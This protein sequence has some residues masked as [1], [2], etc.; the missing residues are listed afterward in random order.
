MKR[1]LLCANFALLCCIGIQAQTTLPASFG[2]D[3][4]GATVSLE[5][6]T[7]TINGHGDLTKMDASFLF[8]NTHD[9]VFAD[10][11]GTQVA[12]GTVFSDAS[13]YYTR[14]DVYTPITENFTETYTTS[15]TDTWREFNATAANQVYKIG[16]DWSSH[17][18]TY[19]LVK[20][21]DKVN[22]TQIWINGSNVDPYYKK[23]EDGTYTAISADEINSDTYTTE[24]SKTYSVYSNCSNVF[25]KKGNTYS[26]VYNGQNVVE[27]RDYF[28]R[29]FDY[30]P[31]S[32]DDL[33]D[34]G[35][36]YSKSKFIDALVEH[37]E[38]ENIVFV[39]DTPSTPLYIN[40]DILDALFYYKKDNQQTWM[41]N[42]VLKELDLGQTT[43]KNLSSKTFQD[44]PGKPNFSLTSL[45]LPLS[46]SKKVPA[47]LFSPN[48][49]A[50]K[51]LSKIVIPE[52]YTAIGD[53]AF[54]NMRIK[55]VVFPST[56][57][58][59]GNY[60]FNGCVSIDTLKLN[61]GL[62][63]IGKYAF[64]TDLKSKTL[65][66][67]L[68]PSTL[69]KIDD[70][71]F[72]NA[73]GLRDITFNE[74]LRYIGNS[75]FGC[76]SNENLGDLTTFTIPSSVRF[77]GS[78]AFFLRQYQDVFFESEVAP[79]MPTG[80]SV[81]NTIQASAKE[82][83]AFPPEC[84]Q[85]NSGFNGTKQEGNTSDDVKGTGYANRE[86]YK[87]STGVY[88]TMLHY[89]NNITD[90]EKLSTYTDTLR[91]Y[92]TW[93]PGQAIDQ[94]YG[95]DNP[96]GKLTVG[97]ETK[98][99]Y[100]WGG[101][102]IYT[103]VDYGFH[104]TYVGDRY[105]WPSQAQWN[106]AYGTALNG[107]GYDGVTPYR[108]KL[109]DEELQILAEAGYVV[110]TGEGQYSLD[111]L[112]EIAHK[113]TRMFVFSNPDT[114][115]HKEYDIKM[116]GGK[117]WTLCVP[118]NMTKKQVDEVFGDE[119]QVCLFNK[120]RRDRNTTTNINSI[121]LFFTLDVCHHKSTKKSENG[122]WEYETIAN[123]PAPEDDDIVIYAHE[124]YMIHPSK[125]P[126]DAVFVVKDYS[127][128]VGNPSPTIIA[129]SE[130]NGDIQ[131]S[132]EEGNEYRFVGNYIGG[133]DAQDICIPQYSYVFAK[134]KNQ[135][136]DYK[137]WFYTGTT[138]LW[139]PNK[140]LVQ[141]ARHDGGVDDWHNFFNTQTNGAQQNSFFGT[142][143]EVDAVEH[144]SIVAGTHVDAPIYT[145]NG[146]MVS[147]NGDSSQ[148]AKGVYIQN[149]KKF[150]VK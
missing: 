5:G 97:K 138:S 18:T 81:D 115:P 11:N 124:S 106:R 1:V 149:G 15:K 3:Q 58:S 4:D 83:S 59:I 93:G 54:V 39:N 36:L 101:N 107:V 14:S 25:Y 8:T 75:A 135:D 56:L 80:A 131:M 61:E 57:D 10:D 119:T 112:Q 38:A 90:K 65:V 63:Y 129:S 141:V 121:T 113:G 68:F 89:P 118:F 137:F 109:T 110:G 20:E 96:Y 7:L 111:S 32:F 53:S 49:V 13:T 78:G 62:T 9:K 150:I 47:R 108:T 103:D 66:S 136:E 45:T 104:D 17:S 51:A 24:K 87:S 72:F 147:R 145:L 48:S 123:N 92:H 50:N 102:Q 69:D 100:G 128:I 42:Q 44:L 30:Q 28:T 12:D 88:F 73:N 29:S 74:G 94:W 77:I 79:L 132:G 43:C 82:L 116:E 34:L 126:E 142:D 143:P 16:Y 122:Y 134:R 46:E 125:T 55:D 60:A 71:A 84:L 21:G 117:W 76:Q 105:V 99:L 31:A 70:A 27:G 2:N 120:V 148:L 22:T 130:T 139:K 86:N 144:I 19:T 127:P 52:G 26:Q 114:Q 35:V 23:G 6:T 133:S 33:W 64:L 98:P 140:S 95:Y 37:C 85:G 67:V 146:V 41:E 91:V 40:Q